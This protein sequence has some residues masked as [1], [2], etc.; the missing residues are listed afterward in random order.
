MKILIADDNFINRQYMRFLMPHFGIECDFA[1][2]GIEAIG[3]IK[4]NKYCCIIMDLFMP[5]MSG[6]ETIKRI[7]KFD[8]TIPIIV[9]SSSSLPMDEEMSLEIGA[10]AFF[11]KPAN[12]AELLE[13]INELCTLAVAS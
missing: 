10:N 3:Y 8:K 2:N 1:T 5:V 6:M 12:E 9:M 11:L 7:R 4:T 13:K